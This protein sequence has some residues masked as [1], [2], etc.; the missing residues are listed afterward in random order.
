MLLLA[1]LAL[2]LLP[3]EDFLV[4]KPLVPSTLTKDADGSLLLSNGLISRRF[5]T[6]PNF[7]TVALRSEVSF[8]TG[9]VLEVLRGVSPEA[10]ITM[11]CPAAAENHR[12]GLLPYAADALEGQTDPN[13]TGS[14]IGSAG[15]AIG[16]LRGQMRYAIYEEDRWN[17]TVGEEDF[18]YESHETAQPKAAWAWAPGQRHS[19][20]AAW[21]PLGLQLR[22]RFAPPAGHCGC[23]CGVRVTVVY[24]LHDGLPTFSKWLEVSNG[25]DHEV[26]V[27]TLVTEELHVAEDAKDR[28]LVETDYMP[29]KTFWKYAQP[30]AAD[31]HVGPYEGN[32]MNYPTWWI[33]PDYEDDVNDQSLHAN[34]AVTTLLLQLQYPLGPWQ[35]L[36]ANGGAYRFMT[37]FFTIC[38]TTEAERQ[39][40]TRRRVMRTL[41]PQVTES[42][43]YFYSTNATSAGIRR[44]AA[45]A[46]EV[47]FEAMLLSF[48]SGFDPASTDPTY[49]ASVASD[50]AFAKSLGIEMGGYTLMQ[51]S[52]GGVT[53][54]DKCISPDGPGSSVD[55]ADFSTAYHQQYRDNI[56]SFLNKTGMAMLET[57]GPYEGATCAVTSK[58]GFRHVNNSQLVQYAANVEFYRQLKREFNTFLTVPDPYWNSGGTNREPAGYTDAWN[59]VDSTA[60]YLQM[61]RL[62]LYDSTVFKPSTEGW[63]GFEMYRTPPPLDDHIETLEEALASLL[64]QGNIPCYRGPEMYDDGSLQA[65]QLWKLWTAHYKRY[66]SILSLC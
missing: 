45:Q 6:T 11:S 53:G 4:D 46:A 55:I 1:F 25:G 54:D 22:V 57:D 27:E 49:I 34:L 14:S 61:A 10:R 26:L 3:S 42:L 13:V 31:P 50:T 29:R 44:V 66:R 38:D 39:W 19:S 58:S 9:G 5:V 64:G 48:G 59:H 24:E 36:A 62:Y 63:L 52:Y 2:G 12:R 7:A 28:L 35:L 41:F 8:D 47:G 40:L 56:V 18:V 65:K 15:I 37:M 21:P 60:E 16:G 23:Y 51:L 30:P 43:L 33:D 20:M 17:W 32:R